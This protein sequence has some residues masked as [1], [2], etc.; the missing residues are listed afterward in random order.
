MHYKFATPL[1][2]YF[3]SFL[4]AKSTKMKL[5]IIRGG[6]CNFGTS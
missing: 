5:I 1:A 4:Y 6:S 3:L 2:F